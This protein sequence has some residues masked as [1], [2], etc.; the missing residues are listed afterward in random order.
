MT[1]FGESTIEDAALNWLAGLGWSIVHGP[2]IAP[3]CDWRSERDDYGEVRAG[4]ASPA[5]DA[6]AQ[7]NPDLPSDALDERLP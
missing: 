2:D 3:G 6:L 5:R 1:T 4:N 7:L